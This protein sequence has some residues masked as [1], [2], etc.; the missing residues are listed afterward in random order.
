MGCNEQKICSNY[1]VDINKLINDACV[2]GNKK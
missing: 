2:V 1:E